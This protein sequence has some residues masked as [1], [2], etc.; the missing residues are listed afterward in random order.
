MA[1]PEEVQKLA[2]LARISI[3]SEKLES[4]AKEFDSIL[5]YV[6]KLDELVLP[7]Q[8]ARAKPAVRNVFRSDGTPHERGKFT[9]ALVAQFPDSL[10]NRLKVRQI[11]SHD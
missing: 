7:A 8:D 2:A 5:A 11:I 10:K 4:F 9:D 3:P 1:S 6:G